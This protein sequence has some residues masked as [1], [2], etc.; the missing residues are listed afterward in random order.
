MTVALSNRDHPFD[1]LVRKVMVLGEE[2]PSEMFVREIEEENM[3]EKVEEKLM[4]MEDEKQ[5]EGME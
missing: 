4:K 5:T 1:E 2:W 3:G